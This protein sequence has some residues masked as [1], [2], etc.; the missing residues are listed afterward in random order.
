M[1]TEYIAEYFPHPDRADL[2][3]RQADQGSA[4]N[5]CRGNRRAFC[6]HTVQARTRPDMQMV[7]KALFS[8]WQMENCTAQ[9]CTQSTKPAKRNSLNPR[10]LPSHSCNAWCHVIATPS[11]ASATACS[12][13]CVESHCFCMAAACDKSGGGNHGPR[14]IALSAEVARDVIPQMEH[15][16]SM[17]RVRYQFGCGHP[18]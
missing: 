10:S 16:P 15:W 7:Q 17:M 9:T 3:S 6:T 2:L 5:M 11:S 4:T 14:P 13:Q 18:L 12:S 8:P 1:R